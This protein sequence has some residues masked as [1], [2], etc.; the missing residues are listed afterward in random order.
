MKKLLRKTWVQ[1]L[2]VYAGLFLLLGVGLE[3]TAISDLVFLVLV[4]VNVIAG[5]I[6]VV[7]TFFRTGKFPLNPQVW[8]KAW[9][10]SPK[11]HE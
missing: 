3:H 10:E 1:V 7:Y 11:N 9:H 8:L 6:Y 5:T 4:I 2:L